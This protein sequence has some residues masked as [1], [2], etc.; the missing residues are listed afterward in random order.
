MFTPD[1]I[2]A[3]ETWAARFRTTRMLDSNG[4]PVANLKIGATA[5]GPGDWE[6]TGIIVKRDAESRKLELIDIFD[7]TRHVVDY[8]DV[9]DIDRA[10][11][12]EDD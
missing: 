9:W 7:Q 10:E 4:K 11:I 12:L 6:S 3:G 8:G 1:D 5:K 2:V